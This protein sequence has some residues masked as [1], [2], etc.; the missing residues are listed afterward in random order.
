[1]TNTPDPN[2]AIE[3]PPSVILLDPPDETQED[4]QE[5][6][7][8]HADDDRQGETIDLDIIEL[9]LDLGGSD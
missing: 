6:S 2:L 9:Y 1:M 7:E 5:A 4:P 8:A 3:T